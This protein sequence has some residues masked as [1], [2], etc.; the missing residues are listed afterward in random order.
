MAASHQYF[1][2]KWSTSVQAPL[3]DSITC[4]RRQWIK[5]YNRF[6]LSSDD[7]WPPCTGALCAPKYIHVFTN[8]SIVFLVTLFSSPI[9]VNK[10]IRF[11]CR[12]S[13]H[14]IFFNRSYTHPL[15]T[16]P[17]YFSSLSFPLSNMCQQINPPSFSSRSILSV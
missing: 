9:P 14:S 8:E 6:S 10:R 5:R 12:R 11:L 15:Q 17:F 4:W 1:R 3:H 7:T 16:N 13:L 2:S